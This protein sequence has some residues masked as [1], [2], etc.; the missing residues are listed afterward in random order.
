MKTTNGISR[1]EAALALSAAAFFAACAVASAQNS[2]NDNV[3]WT[4]PAPQKVTY[5]YP[6]VDHEEQSVGWLSERLTIGLGI[7]RIRLTN[8]HRPP[9]RDAGETFVGYVNLLDLENDFAWTPVVTY[10]AARYFRASLSWENVKAR[11]FNYDK[12]NPYGEHGQTDGIISISGPLVSLEA[13]FPLMDDTLFP[14]AGLGIFFINADFR[15]DDFWHL[16]YSSQESYE[17]YG[18]PKKTRSGYYREIRVDDTVGWLASA[19]IAWRPMKKFQV[20]LD[21]RQTWADV[22]CEFG[23]NYKSGWDP[24]RSGNFTLDNVAWTLSAAYVF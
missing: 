13:V 5:S 18:K 8:N 15:E 9:K 20:D 2:R 7:S 4:R 12:T 14:H 6:T 23:Y 22:D 17:Y 21:V 1:L 19:G 10:W 24:H 16:G 3:I 11:T